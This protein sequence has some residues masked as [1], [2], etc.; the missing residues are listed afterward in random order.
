VFP[1]YFDTCSP[2]LRFV[3]C[4]G[5]SIGRR[6]R[7]VLLSARTF[8]LDWAKQA[9]LVVKIK[10]LVPT[11]KDRGEGLQSGLGTWGFAQNEAGYLPPYYNTVNGGPPG[12][13]N[14]LY[15]VNDGCQGSRPNGSCM[16]DIP[17]E[18]FDSTVTLLAP[19]PVGTGFL[20]RILDSST[21]VDNR[22]LITCEH[23]VNSNVKVR[24]CS[25][26]T[27]DIARNDWTRS[28]TGDDVVAVDRKR[29]SR[30][31]ALGG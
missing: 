14:G 26:Q 23:C 2:T 17:K 22:Y 20:M 24:F 11:S 10:R 21:L 3:V 4:R 9:Q 5:A 19:C 8:L 29:S 27:I 18:F 28:S 7:V 6:G 1:R 30:P 16:P 13:Y 15:H 12:R 25:G 31:T